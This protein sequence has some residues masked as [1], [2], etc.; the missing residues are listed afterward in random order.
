M[1]LILLGKGVSVL[2]QN[3][4]AVSE[5]VVIEFSLMNLQA[6]IMLTSTMF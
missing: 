5:Q 2:K 1:K 4:H 3:V 6:G